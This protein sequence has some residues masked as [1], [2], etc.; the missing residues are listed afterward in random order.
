MKLFYSKRCVLIH[1]FVFSQIGK[2]FTYSVVVVVLVFI[3]IVI[4]I[5]PVPSVR[6]F[7]LF[8]G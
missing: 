6:E 1:T 2:E 3:L 7:C 5:A 8:A 4:A